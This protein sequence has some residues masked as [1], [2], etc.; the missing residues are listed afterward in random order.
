[1]Q[2]DLIVIGSGLSGTMAA[3]KAAFDGKR[4][5]VIR[6]AWGGTA[7]S[8]GAFDIAGPSTP[9]EEE[10]K[11]IGYYYER[12]KIQKP[13]HPYHNLE[14]THLVPAIELLKKSLPFVIKGSYE[15]NSLFLTERGEKIE[16]A[17]AMEHHVFDPQIV[18]GRAFFMEKIPTTSFL[19]GLLPQI[20]AKRLEDSEVLRKF[21]KNIKTSDLKS[22]S[23]L[24]M[25][26]LLGLSRFTEVRSQFENLMGIAVFETLGHSVPGI[27]FQYGLDLA[28]K[29]NGISII[30]GE[31]Q[32]IKTKGKMILSVSLDTKTEVESR[33]FILATGKYFSGGIRKEK[34]FR[35]TVFNLPLFFRNE[36]VCEQGTSY[37]LKKEFLKAQPI[38]EIGVRTNE[39]LEPLNEAS[40]VVYENLRACG[41][42]LMGFD[43]YRQGSRFGVG[44]LSGYKAGSLL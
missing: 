8:N 12:L 41:S 6:K 22:H 16:R 7:L 3:L 29:K 36:R 13:F 39:K 44:L 35:E 9:S 38:F 31:I 20:I 18:S 34:K 30:E 19:Y 11:N 33:H 10:P 4:V 43:P 15:K 21:V 28:L 26:P 23:S 2:V 17:F 37:F 32:K 25:P 14:W 5:V 42:I 1:M 27:R 24:V 40:E